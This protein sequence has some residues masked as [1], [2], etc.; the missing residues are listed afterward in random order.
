MSCMVYVFLLVSIQAF[1]WSVLIPGARVHVHLPGTRRLCY[2]MYYDL[3]YIINLPCTDW[4]ITSWS[5]GLSEISVILWSLQI[6]H[7][8]KYN[9][10]RISTS[11]STSSFDFEKSFAIDVWNIYALQHRLLSRS[12][13][14]VNLWCLLALRYQETTSKVSEKSM[15]LF[16]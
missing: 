11:S 2:Y 3:Y 6:R 9:E 15:E 7:K 5:Y 16:M 8:R 13:S 1:T 12:V 14:K 4:L 10:T